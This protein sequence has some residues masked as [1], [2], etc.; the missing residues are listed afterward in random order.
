MATTKAPR[1][2][3]KSPP[4]PSLND[5]HNIFDIA[6]VNKTIDTREIPFSLRPCYK[7]IT[8]ICSQRFDTFGHCKTDAQ[9][10]DIKR[11]ATRLAS[12]ANRLKN[13][14]EANEFEWRRKTEVFVFERFSNQVIW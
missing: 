2:R 5:L 1:G 11:R 13:D 12:F 3:K 7:I 6:F 9:V 10:A 14:E 4:L 8:E